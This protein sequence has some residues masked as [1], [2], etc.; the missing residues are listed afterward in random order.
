V[1]ADVGFVG[2]GWMG[3]SM[4]GYLVDAGFAVAVHDLD[5]ARVDALARKGARSA[6]G[7][8]GLAECEAVFLSLPGPTEVTEVADALLPLLRPGSLVIN[9]STISPALAR[10]LDEQGAARGI[11]V[12]D[13]PVTGAADGAAAGTLTVMVGARPE[14]LERARPLLEPVSARVFHTGPAGSAS[15]VKLLTNML[16]FVHVVALSDALAVGAAAGVDPRVLGEVVRA[17]AGASWVSD[18][19]LDNI[20]AGEDDETFTLALSCKD[21]GLISELTDSPLAALARE[22]FAAALERFGP[23]AGDLAVAR[24]AEEAAGVSIRESVPA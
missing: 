15:V 19:D 11:D 4:A 22:R 2:L 18:H 1:A 13:A 9:V 12:L 7:I 23:A 17:S 21:L 24:L 5:P 10:R 16:W 3:A 20:L 14:A 8:D 6:N